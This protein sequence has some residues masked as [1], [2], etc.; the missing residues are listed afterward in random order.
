MA[1]CIVPNRISVRKVVTS[2]KWIACRQA[3]RC[4]Y[5]RRSWLADTRMDH[6]LINR[7]SERSEFEP[8]CHVQ[9]AADKGNNR[10]IKGH[11]HFQPLCCCVDRLFFTNM[12]IN[13]IIKI[14]IYPVIYLNKYNMFSLRKLKLYL[15]TYCIYIEK[16]ESFTYLPRV[17]PR[18]QTETFHRP[19]TVS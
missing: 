15:S 4:T 16:K 13:Y 12:A 10:E 6:Q 9:N 3:A 7:D 1:I 2:R 19:H 17:P 11:L 8:F 18:C 5:I 14:S